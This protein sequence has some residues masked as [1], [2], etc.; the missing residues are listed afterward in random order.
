MSVTS[1]HHATCIPVHVNIKIQESFIYSRFIREK[2]NT[3]SK[4]LLYRH[5]MI[6]K[7]YIHIKYIKKTYVIKTNWITFTLLLMIVAPLT[8]PLNSL[9]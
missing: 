4:E 7:I 1:S 8:E 5:N 9:I 2:D 6:H 3:S